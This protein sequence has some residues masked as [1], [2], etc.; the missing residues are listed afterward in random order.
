MSTN[1]LSNDLSTLSTK[2]SHR[3]KPEIAPISALM[4]AGYSFSDEFLAGKPI[5]LPVCPVS[6]RAAFGISLKST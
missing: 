6:T 5:L 3:V 2:P 1:I 4:W